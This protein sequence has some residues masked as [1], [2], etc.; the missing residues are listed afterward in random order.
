VP[1]AQRETTTTHR[2]RDAAE[3]RR[4]LLDAAGRRFARDGYTA[5]TVRDIADEAG[6]NV[7]L[8]SRYFTSKEGLFE[9]CLAAAVNE[10]RRESDD[11]PLDGIAAA[12][13]DRIAG[14]THSGRL[15]ETLLLLMR[16]SGDEHVDEIRAGF[17]LSISERLAG[18]AAEPDLLRAQILL[19]AT[20]GV[21]L[22][23]SSLSIQP[24]AGATEQDLLPPM[25]DLVSA[26][27]GR[28]ED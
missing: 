18:T 27:L 6:V 7:A 5:T 9:A 4:L 19:A 11:T 20:L 17:L 16:S 8:I 25:A 24:L 15:P 3:T 23:R 2:R 21:T 13:A 10:I 1:T 22:L 14:S 28:G 26:L 12:M